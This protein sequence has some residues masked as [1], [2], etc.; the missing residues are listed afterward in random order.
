[1]IGMEGVRKEGGMVGRVV[2]VLGRVL[3][4]GFDGFEFGFE[5]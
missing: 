2:V 4:G 3:N 5:N 1:M